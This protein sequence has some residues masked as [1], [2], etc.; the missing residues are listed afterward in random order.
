MLFDAPEL[1]EPEFA[2]IKQIDELRSN[3]RFMLAEPRRWTGLLARVMFARSMQGSNSI[4]GYNVTV[5]DAVA[6]IAKDSALETSGES[7]KAIL[8]Y[9]DAMTYILR[10]SG[11]V[12]F[13]YQEGF[14]RSLHYMLMAHDP[15]KHPGTWRRGPVFV[16]REESGE[17]VYEGAPV[18]ELPKTDPR[19]DG[20]AKHEG[21]HLAHG[22]GRDGPSQS[23]NDSSLL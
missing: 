12:H 11:D 6:A 8:G 9:R 17:T 18:E 22:L 23:S 16:R 10:L 5:N 1:R 21:Q 3:L 15:E 20:T 13:E 7:W 2:I 4:E 14:I 19:I